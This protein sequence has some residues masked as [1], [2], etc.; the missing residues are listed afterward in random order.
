MKNQTQDK[1]LI[2]TPEK[3]KGFGEWWEGELDSPLVCLFG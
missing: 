3:R 2:L 1:D